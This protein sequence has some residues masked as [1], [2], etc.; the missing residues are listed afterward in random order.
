MISFEKKIPSKKVQTIR[1]NQLFHKLVTFGAFFQTAS[2]APMFNFFPTNSD[3]YVKIVSETRFD[4]T[5]A[6]FRL[7]VRKHT[8]LILQK[9]NSTVNSLLRCQ[10]ISPRKKFTPVHFTPVHFTPVHFTPV[11]FTPVH[12]TPKTFHH[13]HTSPQ[14]RFTPLFQ[15][16]IQ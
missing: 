4:L 5:K 6:Y 16:R 1:T 2:R 14:V 7:F 15:K 9:T 10:N 13:E 11:D 12:F 3:G 8:K